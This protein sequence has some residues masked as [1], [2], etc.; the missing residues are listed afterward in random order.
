MK[1]HSFTMVGGSEVIVNLAQIVHI[2]R[3][4]DANESVLTFNSVIEGEPAYL[5]I[6]GTPDTIKASGVLSQ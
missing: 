3:N 4:G 1:F 5:I 2:T 6:K